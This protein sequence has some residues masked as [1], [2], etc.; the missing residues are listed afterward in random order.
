MDLKGSSKPCEHCAVCKAKQQTAPQI[1][2]GEP[3]KEGE[4][5]VH[6]DMRSIIAFTN[7]SSQGYCVVTK[8]N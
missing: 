1:S 4:R 8:R 5:R 2:S 6:L 3:L 7:G